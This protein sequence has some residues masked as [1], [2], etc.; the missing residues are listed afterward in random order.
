MEIVLHE[1]LSFCKQGTG[2]RL[3]QRW[4]SASATPSLHSTAAIS[5]TI[6]HDSK[7]IRN[8]ESCKATIGLK[9]FVNFYQDLKRILVLNC[10]LFLGRHSF[11]WRSY[12]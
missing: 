3:M 1:K 10:K 11:S 4:N 7:T 5:Q 8:F 6:V 9:M 2:L 12:P